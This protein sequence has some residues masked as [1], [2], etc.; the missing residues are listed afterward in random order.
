MKKRP[1]GAGPF[2][3]LTTQRIADCLAPIVPVAPVA[4]AVAIVPVVPAIA[5]AASMLVTGSEPDASDGKGENGQHGADKPAVHFFLLVDLA[6]QLKP[7]ATIT[8]S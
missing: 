4:I 1:V 6:S 2:L 3:T 8:R 5:V 7:S